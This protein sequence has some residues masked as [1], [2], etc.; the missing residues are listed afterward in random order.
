MPSLP[1]PSKP[2]QS[3]RQT[4]FSK[5]LKTRQAGYCPIFSCKR[6]LTLPA[7]LS[8]LSLFLSPLPAFLC[9]FL[10][11]LLSYPIL[12]SVRTL[13]LLAG[14]CLEMP[15]G[16]QGG[17]L[18]LRVP[19]GFYSVSPL[20]IFLMIPFIYSRFPAFSTL[21]KVL[22]RPIRRVDYFVYLMNL[23]LELVLSLKE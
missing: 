3:R 19:I 10:F 14:I 23:A 20:L 21:S 12:R 2:T 15:V 7:R 13:F 18:P 1:I 8:P 5:A 16:T 4:N 9:I 6:R 22:I 11:L 17:L